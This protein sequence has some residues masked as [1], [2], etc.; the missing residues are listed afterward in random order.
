MCCSMIFDEL[1]FRLVLEQK[2]AFH[3]QIRRVDLQDQ[4]GIDHGLVFVVHLARDRVEIVLI[5]LV[6]GVEHGGG[7]DSRRRLGEE[8]L[9][10]GRFD[11]GGLVLEAGKLGLDRFLVVIFELAHRLG[12]AEHLAGLGQAGLEFLGEQRQLDPLAAER[13]L[14]FAAETGHALRH[15]GLKTHPALLAIIGNIDAGPALLLHHMGDALLDSVLELGLVDRLAGLVGDQEIVELRAAR[16]TAGVR[17]QDVV[18]ALVHDVS[19]HWLLVGALSRPPIRRATIPARSR[20]HKLRR[21]P[22]G[23]V[24][25][26]RNIE[27][28]EACD[29]RLCGEFPAR[30]RSRRAGGG[31]CGPI[32]AT[33]SP[34]NA[35][36]TRT[37]KRRRSRRSRHWNA[38]TC[39][40]RA[41]SA[42]R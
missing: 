2:H 13:P 29:F 1:L 34:S 14:R 19:S 10:E 3:R 23:R 28:R 30:F 32:G 5:G 41:R 37:R 38:A 20:G 16:Q 36:A 27:M 22:A 8:H 7:D 18:D 17:D 9:R 15:V 12:A 11:R 31:A 21:T 24:P 6:V 39:C 25:R 40:A 26:T 4:S 42:S 33:S 35:V